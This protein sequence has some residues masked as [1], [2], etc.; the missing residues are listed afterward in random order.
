[1]PGQAFP[2]FLH[3]ILGR[4]RKE[5]N[6]KHRLTIPRQTCW[7]EDG[8]FTNALGNKIWSKAHLWHRLTGPA[9]EGKGYIAYWYRGLRHNLKGQSRVY[10]GGGTWDLLGMRTES[11]TIFRT[12][13]WRRKCI[14]N[15]FTEE[16]N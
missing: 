8:S 10:P 14:L 5:R 7:R 1:M 15:Y 16:F 2:L 9:F 12:K 11:E 3:R 6:M 13:A 4:L